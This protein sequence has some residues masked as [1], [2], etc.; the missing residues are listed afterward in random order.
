MKNVNR[1][2]DIQVTINRKT[3]EFLS[4]KEFLLVLKF[5]RKTVEVESG[6]S[7]NQLSKQ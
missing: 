4:F 3:V 6:N 5:A 7:Q 2:H 1:L